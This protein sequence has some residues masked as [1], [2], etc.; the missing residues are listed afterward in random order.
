[1]STSLLI[2]LVITRHVQFETQTTLC[3]KHTCCGRKLE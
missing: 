2:T 1:M 3:P